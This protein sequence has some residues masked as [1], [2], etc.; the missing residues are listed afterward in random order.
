VKITGTNQP[1][2]TQLELADRIQSLN[3]SIQALAKLAIS[4]AASPKDRPPA[5]AQVEAISQAAARMV[6]LTSGLRA[7]TMRANITQ[8]IA[9]ATQPTATPLPEGKSDKFYD[10]ALIGAN[11]RAYSASTPLNQVPPIKP[12]NGKVPTETII[13]VNGVGQTNGGQ[14]RT[15]QDIANKTGAALVG[16]HNA[17]EGTLK[18][19]L[20]SLGDKADIG[21]NPAVDSVADSVYDAIKSGQ[22]IHL[23]GHSQGGLIIS[24]ALGDVKRRLLIEDGLSLSQAEKLM[25]KVQVETFGAAASSYPDGPQY[26]HYVNRVDPVPVLFGLGAFKGIFSGDRAAGRGAVVHRFT[27]FGGDLHGFEKVYLSRRV[28]FDQA[29]RGQF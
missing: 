7:G 9:V 14:A 6:E 20:Q 13:Y 19:L 24:R 29:R 18:D 2:T 1:G 10:G 21:K 8:G 28:P 17:T 25:S 23:M 4:I 27:T 16:I 3:N 5:R 15:L 12:N 26:V 11:G 22:S